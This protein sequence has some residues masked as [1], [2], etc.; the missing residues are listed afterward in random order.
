MS[1]VNDPDPLKLRLAIAGVTSTFS[2]SSASTSHPEYG[3]RAFC[4]A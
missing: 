1:A 2:D 4:D 3:A